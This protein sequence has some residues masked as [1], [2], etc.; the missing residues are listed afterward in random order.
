MAHRGDPE[1]E[2]GAALL[3][4]WED[5]S[6]ADVRLRCSDG[7]V[8]AAHRVVLAASS[9]FFRALFLGAGRSMREGG[10]PE[11]ELPLPSPALRL[12]LQA[13]YRN[14]AA[15]GVDA[16]SAEAL[17]AAASYLSV[18]PVAA[19]CCAF[20]RRHL[21]LSTAV[22]T[23]L[24]AERLGCQ[25]LREDAMRFLRGRLRE[26]LQGAESTT[27]QA[28]PPALLQELLDSDSLEVGA[29]GEVAQAAAVFA[30][31][32]PAAAE[33]HL[34]ALLAAARA[35]LEDDEC[36]RGV[37][38]AAALLDPRPPADAVAAA[39]AALA[40]AAEGQRGR[41]AQR[42]AAGGA[43]PPPRHG[44]HTE[45]M[46]A[47]GLDE[48]WRSLK[49][50]ELYDPRLDAWRPGPSM[51]APCSLAAACALGG[52]AYVVEGA[53][54][55]PAVLA[56]D[57]RT[58]RWQQ[59]RKMGTPRVNMAA[60]ALPGALYVMVRARV[61]PHPDFA[62]CQHPP[63]VASTRLR[64]RSQGGRAG[65]GKAG[66]SLAT[67]ELFDAGSGTWREAA[68]MGA[69]RSS[70]GAAA[71]GGRVFAVGGQSDRGVHASVEV[72]DAGSDRW[73]AAGAPMRQARKYLAVAAA[74][75]QILAVGGM[76]ERRQRLAAVEAFDPREGFWRA[77]AP[78]R[79]ARSSCGAAVLGGGEVFVVGGTVG[80]GDAHDG[81]EC[82][83]A[84]AGRWR[85][86]A[87]LAA[88]RSGL[89]VAPV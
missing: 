20:L 68:S 78:L 86:C 8:V 30:L 51:P 13:V 81:V 67:V 6:L 1:D 70:L 29:E 49:T 3:T 55:S 38:A 27:L 58:Q 53:A 39:A 23:L 36:R 42:V 69:P 76:C 72:Y 21:G 11:V 31:A 37:L 63:N 80:A 74:A 44:T 34:P 54:H 2:S 19:A 61:L 48:G 47:G 26:L 57:R 79:V 59:L 25:G 40:A 77:L 60:A 5:G 22:D 66:V 28:L 64:C 71:L 17:L 88:A 73:A 41:W 62:C 7:E 15:A 14:D 89:A 46:V 52:R 45:L 50:T 75:G 33:P 43:P 9:P 12:L 4:L 32:D 65:S 85:A 82:W 87:P 16:S 83:E 56:Y 84:A 24:L 10:A 18:A 35:P